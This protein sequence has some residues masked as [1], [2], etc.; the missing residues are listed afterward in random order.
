MTAVST[1]AEKMN[2]PLWW[3]DLRHQATHDSV[4]SLPQLKEATYKALDWLKDNY[5]DVPE[6]E[7]ISDEEITEAINKYKLTRKNYL[8][9]ITKNQFALSNSMDSTGYPTYVAWLI[10]LMKWDLMVKKKI[11]FG[12]DW[13]E[14]QSFCLELLVMNSLNN[15]MVFLQKRPIN[16]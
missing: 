13:E 2:L 6:P 7:M 12:I 8:K 5:W 14:V 9:E 16:V 4:P 1:L 3:V 10:Q 15:L 11:G